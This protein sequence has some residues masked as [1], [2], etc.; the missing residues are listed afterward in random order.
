MPDGARARSTRGRRRW[1]A[2]PVV[3]PGTGDNMAAALGLGLRP[4]RRRDLARHVGHRLRR[5][6]TH[7]TADADAARS[8]AS[9]TP[10]AASCP[11][12]CTLNATKVTDAVARLLGV[13]LDELDTLALADAARRRRRRPA[14][15]P[16]RRAHARTGPT[17]PAC[18][19]GL[20]SRR[21]PRAAGPR[22]VRGRGLRAARRPRRAG[23]AG[24]RRQATA[25]CVLVGGGARSAAYRQVLADLV[26]ARRSRCRPSTST[27]PPGRAC[28]PPR[29]ST[30]A[31]PRR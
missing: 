7:P 16:R 19:P 24:G 28:R 10:P 8:P 26:R 11:L 23:R 29:C 18:S 25:G 14:A 15:V 5:R 2:A 3:G 17:P 27:W 1:R 21:Q 12:V 20:R 22:R 6:A 4:R 13:D 30:S 9:P 31:R